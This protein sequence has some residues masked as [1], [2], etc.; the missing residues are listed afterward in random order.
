MK[1]TQK[2]VYMLITGVLLYG[3]GFCL[4]CM[5]IFNSRWIILCLSLMHYGGMLLSLFAV[6]YFGTTY[7]YEKYPEESKQTLIDLND[8]RTKSIHNLAK[9]RTFNIMTY[10]LM[11]LPAVLI[12]LKA[13]LVGIIGAGAALLIFGISYAFFLAKYKKEL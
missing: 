10:V 6:N 8:E 7:Q 1:T 9:A 12:D 11:L 2:K 3:I 5:H 13:G 4:K